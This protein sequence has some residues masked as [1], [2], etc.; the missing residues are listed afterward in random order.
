VAIKRLPINLYGHEKREKLRNGIVGEE[1]IRDE[2][3]KK[4]RV[5]FMAVE[6]GFRVGTALACAAGFDPFVCVN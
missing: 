4:V 2:D 6:A 1:I 3:T 5:A